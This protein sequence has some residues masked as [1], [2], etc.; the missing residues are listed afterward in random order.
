MHPFCWSIRS[1]RGYDRSRRSDS[2][3]YVGER[4]QRLITSIDT[5]KPSDG[6]S[7]T[8]ISGES[9]GVTGFVRPVGGCW[10][11]DFKLSRPGAEVFQPLPE[12]WTA[13][14][15]IIK[16]SLSVGD[17]GVSGSDKV[18]AKHHTLVLSTQ[19]GQN[20]VLLRR[21]A[22]ANGDGGGEL[23]EDTHFVLVA[24]EP[25]NQRV[26]QYGPFVVN[27]A[28]QARQAVMDYQLGQNG[29]EGAPGWK[30]EIGKAMRH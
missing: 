21:P 8:V 19:P 12:G 4:T 13:F 15:Y 6:V 10:F 5:V 17:A 3:A 14:A 29:F 26:V 25:L 9:H 2:T 28:E 30:S 22:S 27:T 20:G 1:W 7:I 11:M 23:E 18:H 16:G 24:G